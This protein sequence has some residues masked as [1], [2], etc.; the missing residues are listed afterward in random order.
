MAKKRD[1]RRQERRRHHQNVQAERRRSFR[2]TVEEAAERGAR[3]FGELAQAAADATVDPPDV[4]ARAVEL[5]GNELWGVLLTFPEMAVDQGERL[6]EALDEDRARALAA[7][8]STAGEGADARLSWLAV[9]VAE[10]VG[11]LE[12]AERVASAALARREVARAESDD[13]GIAKADVEAAVV[14]A[15]LRL[16]SGAVGDALEV[17]DRYCALAPG[18]D[19]LQELRAACFARVLSAGSETLDGGQLAAAM[20]SLDRFEDRSLLYELRAAVDAFVDADP[21]LAGWRSEALAEFVAD[22]GEMAGLGPLERLGEHETTPSSILGDAGPSVARIEGYGALAVEHLWLISPS[23][24]DE[25][26][27][28]AET[29]EEAD[30]GSP[31]ARFAADPAVAP[32]LAAAARDWRSHVRYGLWQLDQPPEKGERRSAGMWVTDL[33]TRRSVYAAFAPEQV[34]GLP[35]WC[36]LACALAPVGGV[37]RSGAVAVMLD[38]AQA[39]LAVDA[40]LASVEVVIAGLAKERGMRAPRA[41]RRPRAPRPHG[42]LATMVE[43][44][45]EAE[46]DLNAK[47]LGSSLAQLVGMLEADARRPPVLT[48]TDGDPVEML[49][50]RYPATDPAAVRRRLL[51]GSDFESD[52][53]EMHGDDVGAPVR[54]LGREMTATEAAS[55]LAQLR[56]EAAK[57]GWGPIEEPVGPRR[58]LRGVLR[59]EPSGVRVEVNSRRRFDDLTMLLRLVGAGEPIV[60]RLVDP[61]LDLPVRGGRPL[62]GRGGEPEAEAAWLEHW[63]DE[64][65]PALGGATPRA[66]ADDPKRRVLLESLLRRFEFDADLAAAGGQRPRDVERLRASLGMHAGGVG[67][68]PGEDAGPTAAD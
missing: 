62:G 41:G 64:P 44:M 38:P 2:R 9:G 11:D 40:V 19:D 14:A 58:W 27:S 45:E 59:F 55:S 50:A 16:R 10:S 65:V 61:A 25:D 48:N 7:A 67:G 30:L 36:V 32:E 12:E 39:D 51:A 26:G 56:A 17:L 1:R 57:K 5:L 29:D 54:W 22:A 15:S 24:K 23:R 18:S 3:A 35:R 8:L 28:D 66:A 46:A 43:P 47:V 37:W 13:A 21:E 34:E 63:L 4:A 60:E 20:A 42:V 49:V 53:D 52:D 33:V 6:A 31:L 68:P